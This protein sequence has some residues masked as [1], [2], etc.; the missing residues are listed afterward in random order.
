[1]HG[2]HF[3]NE[4]LQQGGVFRFSESIKRVKSVKPAVPAASLVWVVCTSFEQLDT[5]MITLFAK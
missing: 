3:F 4:N 2:F 5:F 1:M